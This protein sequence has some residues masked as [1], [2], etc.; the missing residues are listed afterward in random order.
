MASFYDSF[1]ASY[2][3]F[4]NWDQRLAHE[5]PFIERQLKAHGASTISNIVTTLVFERAAISAKKL[6]ITIIGGILRTR[7]R[8]K[9]EKSIEMATPMSKPL[10]MLDQIIVKLT[11]TGRIEP[12]NR[13]T[14]N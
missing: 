7:V 5:T 9:I 2:D 8:G 10:K 14:D 1:G 3:R 4:V 6:L 11:S 12:N 13:G